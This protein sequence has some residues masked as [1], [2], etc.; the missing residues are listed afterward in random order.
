MLKSCKVILTTILLGKAVERVIALTELTNEA[1]KGEDGRLTGIMR[2]FGVN[3]SDGNLDRS[4]VLSLD[5]AASGSALSGDV[6]VNK[7][8]FG[9][10][11]KLMLRTWKD[12]Q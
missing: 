6:K 12:G 7:V 5:D 9:C 4:V 8:S 2:P 1:G 3:V 11:I 10:E